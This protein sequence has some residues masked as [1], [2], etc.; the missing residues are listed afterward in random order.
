MPED[1]IFASLQTLQGLRGSLSALGCVYSAAAATPLLRCEAAQA[2]F[3]S[4]RAS[5]GR[6]HMNIQ[7]VLSVQ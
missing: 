1:N 5:R 4:R 2:F 3:S 6:K 7:N